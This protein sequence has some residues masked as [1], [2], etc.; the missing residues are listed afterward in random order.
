M[1]TVSDLDKGDSLSQ[2]QTR[3][4]IWKKE[5]QGLRYGASGNVSGTVLSGMRYFFE[6]YVQWV[7]A[8]RMLTMPIS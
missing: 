7:E 3:S 8:A 6:I 4:F 5:F 1:S 2:P